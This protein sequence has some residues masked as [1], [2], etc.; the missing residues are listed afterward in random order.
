MKGV[1]QITQLP[2]PPQDELSLW[3]GDFLPHIFPKQG[4]RR[5]GK[6]RAESFGILIRQVNK[7]TYHRV[8]MVRDPAW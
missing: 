7:V 1:S 5:V 4:K 8:K 3:I 2:P 6:G